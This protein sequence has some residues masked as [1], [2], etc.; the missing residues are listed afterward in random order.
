MERPRLLLTGF[1]P[2][3][4]AP[5]NPT[6]EVI[7]RLAERGDLARRVDLVV[8]VLP[9]TWAAIATFSELVETVAPDAVLATGLARRAR[10]IRVE[11]FASTRT[12]VAAVDAAGERARPGA[13]AS[14]FPGRRV[15]TAPVE[16]L[17]AAIA[18]LGLPVEASGDAG[19]YL[20]NGLLRRAIE[21]AGERP[22]AF[23]HLPPTRDL[24]P[25]SRFGVRDLERAVAAAIPPLV[26]AI[27]RG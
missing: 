3:P 14:S 10:T 22:V 15:A 9:V 26:A 11:R 13:L 24:A 25:A 1:G 17:V 27:R 4:G 6:A 18:A 2:F 5:R 8:R 21:T 19:T 7:A 16:A 12:M 20:C 23:L